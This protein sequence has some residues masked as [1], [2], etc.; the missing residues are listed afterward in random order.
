MHLGYTQL[1]P[2]HSHQEIQY[3]YMFEMVIHN[4]G[5]K[6]GCTSSTLKSFKMDVIEMRINRR[7]LTLFGVRV[8]PV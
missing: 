5:F 8:L 4:R 7:F 2:H 1:L 6:T 3:S